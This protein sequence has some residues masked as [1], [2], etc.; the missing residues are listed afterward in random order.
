MDGN[1]KQ[2]LEDFRRKSIS[3]K[4]GSPKNMTMNTREM[5]K[6]IFF[7]PLNQRQGKER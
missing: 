3:M 2:L 6:L 1:P 4:P 7:W 5:V